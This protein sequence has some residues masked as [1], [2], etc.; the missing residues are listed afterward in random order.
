MSRMSLKNRLDKL[1][2]E[3]KDRNE[4]PIWYINVVSPNPEENETL[5]MVN[6]EIVSE[7]IDAHESK[8]T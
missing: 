7:D 3:T 8:K 5:V 1:E 4:P 2:S 6:G